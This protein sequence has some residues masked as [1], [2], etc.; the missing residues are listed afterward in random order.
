MPGVK[1]SFSCMEIWF[2]CKE[3]SFSC[4]KIS[5]F[6]IRDLFMH[7]TF[8]VVPNRYHVKKHYLGGHVTGACVTFTTILPRLYLRPVVRQWKLKRAEK[9][10]TI[11][12]TITNYC[13]LDL[14]EFLVMN[15]TRHVSRSYEF[16]S[17]T[18]YFF[19]SIIVFSSFRYL[20]DNS[21]SDLGEY[22]L[23]GLPRLIVLWVLLYYNFIKSHQ[24]TNMR[25]TKCERGN[26]KN[27]IFTIVLGKTKYKNIY[28]HDRFG[29]RK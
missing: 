21:I 14:G 25:W 19:L 17:Y 6:S 1:F 11:D 23:Y 10:T 4:I 2:L 9:V 13:A 20:N 18:N 12:H 7:E 15:E 5:K 16:I 8:S 29:E 28:L 24:M 3:I 22:A 26:K 27:L